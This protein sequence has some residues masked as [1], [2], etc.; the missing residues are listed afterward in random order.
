MYHDRH[1]DGFLR[2]D[3]FLNDNPAQNEPSDDFFHVF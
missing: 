2:G 1:S 3:M